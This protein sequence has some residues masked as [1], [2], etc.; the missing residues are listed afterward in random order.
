[1][2]NLDATN[3]FIK[4]THLQY[5][6][7]LKHYFGDVIKGFF[8]DEAGFY[9]NLYMFP[10]RDDVNT[11][12]W[13]EGFLDYFKKRNDYSIIEFLPYLWEASEM[14]H[15][16]R[17]DYYQTVT[18]LYIESFF[19]PQRDF[20]EQYHMS[21]IGHVDFEDFLHM[22]I[23]VQGDMTKVLGSL[24]YAG[25]DK[26]EQ[27]NEKIAEK[28]ISSIGH[29]YHHERVLSETYALCGWSL[30]F[31]EMKRLADYQYVRGIN[32]LN[33]HAFYASIEDKRKWEC[34]PSQFT[35]NPYWP[36]YNRFSNY[37]TRL[38]YILS[39]GT[40]IA[41]VAIYYPMPTA[42]DY[43]Q[44][45]DRDDVIKIDQLLHNLTFT[46]M[47]NQYDFDFINDEAI[48]ASQIIGNHLVMNDEQFRMMIL[49]HVSTLMYETTIKLKSYVNAGGRLLML[50]KKPTKCVDLARQSEFEILIDE[51]FH[52]ENTYFM[53][54]YM[55]AKSY[56]YK[57]DIKKFDII[58][59]QIMP[60]EDFFKLDPHL[61]IALFDM[62]Y[63][64]VLDKD[65]FLENPD[66]HIKYL[67]RR[68]DQLEIYYLINEDDSWRKNKIRLKSIGLLKEMDLYD[69]RFLSCRSKQMG[70]YLAFD[71]ILPPLGSKLY[72]IDTSLPIE[73]VKVQEIVECTERK[74]I[75]PWII[76]IDNQIFDRNL[77][78]WEA[79]GY[80]HYSGNA[81]YEKEITIHEDDLNSQDILLV[82]ENFRDCVELYLNDVYIDVKIWEPY[83]F[84]I[85]SFLFK[86]N[87]KIKMKV[88]NTLLNEFE[89][90]PRQSGIVN[91]VKLM[92]YKS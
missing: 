17:Y 80:P 55:L 54:W 20:C 22:Q 31:Q 84:S 8:T 64:N 50:A 11:V 62:K 13:T 67:H 65:V 57:F 1:M 47:E 51:I 24:T 12:V 88:I 48:L 10:N 37:M 7:R 43:Y 82:I 90:C 78:S 92:F 77:Q 69:G 41:D 42:Y 32:M 39:Q 9:N 18:D 79:L 59:H 15:K 14:S 83:Q 33:P 26:I 46:L 85:K 66:A 86:G 3:A 30:D 36:Y 45:Q 28:L 19:K 89:K 40:H 52:H 44:P 34:P 71:L 74:L 58:Y 73:E 87:N 27:N 21:L 23:S 56:T 16:I 4:L 70:S 25:V 63:S 29:M 60:K 2:L 61:D 81:I 68:I 5:E 75:G 53:D 76:S 6:S 49:P 72:V 38:S 35:Q 91:P